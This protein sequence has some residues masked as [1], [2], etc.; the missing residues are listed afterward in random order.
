MRFEG[1]G[2]TK[3]PN[4]PGPLWLHKCAAGQTGG[5]EGIAQESKE[6]SKQQQ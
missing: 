4:G 3:T 6:A 2:A 1:A 5:A